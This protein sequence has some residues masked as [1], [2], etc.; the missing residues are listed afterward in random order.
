MSG[1]GS[2]LTGVN[3]APGM[4]WAA[5]RPGYMRLVFRRH[6]GVE[7]FVVAGPESALQCGGSEARRVRCLE[8]EVGAFTTS[9]SIRLR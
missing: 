8:E 7:L 9:F 1:A 6:G 3:A 5:S 2:K 4:R